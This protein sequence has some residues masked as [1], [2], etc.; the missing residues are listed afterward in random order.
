MS[1]PT[2]EDSEKDPRYVRVSSIAGWI[3]DCKL[4]KGQ[5]PLVRVF[6]G[7]DFEVLRCFVEVNRP[8][9]LADGVG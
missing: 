3:F 6:A 2:Q 9:L 7:N 4:A 1:E 8:D 5:L